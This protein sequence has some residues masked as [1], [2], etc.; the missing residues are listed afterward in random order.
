MAIEEWIHPNLIAFML[1][2]PA[3][4]CGGL[5]L[6]SFMSRRVT[7]SRIFSFLIL[8]AFIWSMAY[9]LEL[10]CLRLEPMLFFVGLEYIGIVSIPPLWL[11]LTLIYTG[12]GKQVTPR[13]AV[14][15]FII[16]AITLLL[17]ITN[18]FHHL[19]YSRVSVDYSGR[20]RCWP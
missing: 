6:H 17:N 9:G 3:V 16:P 2:L 20:S 7:G 5:A 15:L 1:L 13:A 14:F 10:C 18:Q 4:I 19:Y 8:A 12:R 11:I